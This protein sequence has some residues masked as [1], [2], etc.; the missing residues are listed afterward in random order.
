MECGKAPG[1]WAGAPESAG[2]YSY[3]VV[4]VGHAFRPLHLHFSMCIR[5]RSVSAL[6]TLLV[7]WD[8]WCSLLTVEPEEDFA[9]DVSLRRKLERD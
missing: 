4:G 2:K 8:V 6:L 5:G 7:F 9:H 3:V 1:Q